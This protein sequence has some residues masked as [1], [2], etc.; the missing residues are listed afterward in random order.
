[1]GMCSCVF[2]LEWLEYSVYIYTQRSAWGIL[3]HL[4]VS[5]NTRRHTQQY[6]YMYVYIYRYMYV[7][8]YTC[9]HMKIWAPICYVTRIHVSLG[10]RYIYNLYMGMYIYI[11]MYIYGACVFGGGV[12][13]VLTHAYS[14]LPC[15]HRALLFFVAHLLLPRSSF[16]Q[17]NPVFLLPIIQVLPQC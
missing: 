9:T 5:S 12:H 15:L 16:P 17:L 2:L 13:C 3:I 7:C 6:M 8:I 11:E 1:M 4:Y 14:Y 10:V